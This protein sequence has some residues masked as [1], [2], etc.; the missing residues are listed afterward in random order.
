MDIKDT[1]KNQKT[2]TRLV[3]QDNKGILSTS[4]RVQKCLI[5]NIVQKSNHPIHLSCLF[6]ANWASCF[7]IW[8]GNPFLNSNLYSQKLIFLIVY[9]SHIICNFSL[10]MNMLQCEKVLGFILLGSKLSRTLAK[11][12]GKLKT[13]TMQMKFRKCTRGLSF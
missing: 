13:R 11:T 7:Q 12:V 4:T 10:F 1:H 2:Y 5:S 9:D 6:F 8:M 3:L